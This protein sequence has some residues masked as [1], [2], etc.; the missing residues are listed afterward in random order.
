MIA[1]GV[2]PEDI[3]VFDNMVYGHEEHLPRGVRLVRGDLLQ[4]DDLRSAFGMGH[5]DAVIHFAAYAYVGESMEKPGKYFENNVH[6][7]VNLLEAMRENGCRNIIF[8]S[9]CAVYGLPDIVPITEAEKRA[10]INPYGESKLMF[11]GILRW[12]DQLMGLR[13]VALRYFNAA[14]AAFGIG[15]DHSPETHLIPLTMQAA[16]GKRDC[17]RIFGTDYDTPDGSCIRDYIHVVDLAEAHIKA[18]EMLKAGGD[19]AAVNLGTGKG[20][21]VRE[22]ID[23]VGEAAGKPVPTLEDPRRPGDPA[24]LVAGGDMAERVLGWTP[25]YGIRDVIQSAWEWHSQKGRQP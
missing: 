1:S 25:K 20:V 17:I 8:S 14:G 16:L 23:L 22:I 19:S 21:S 3:I 5:V 11:E 4:K 15:E 12:Y 7:G 13:F 2:S 10:P 6:G 24:L 9:T 18:L